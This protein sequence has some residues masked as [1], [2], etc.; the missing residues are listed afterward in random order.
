MDQQDDDSE[1]DNNLVG[2]SLTQRL[3][4]AL[5]DVLS[6]RYLYA[7]RSI[8]KSEGTFKLMKNWKNNFPD[9]FRSYMR[10]SPE[11]FDALH[12]TIGDDTVFQNES[13]NEQMPV[14]H[15]LMIAL[16]RFGHFGNGA[17]VTKIANYFGVAFGTVINS[18][19]R[20]MT[21][22]CNESFRLSV[23]RWPDADEKEAA[24]AWVEDTS[25]YGWRDG[26]LM[27][28]GTLVPLFG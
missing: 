20:V 6:H 9:I 1:D 21:A 2:P 8:P 26:W 13:Q 27:V 10:M 16:Y 14:D 18:T 7:A 17:S 5:A 28:D 25:C 22:I 3:R 23:M 12:H 11:C 15:Q 19:K 24:K 4:D